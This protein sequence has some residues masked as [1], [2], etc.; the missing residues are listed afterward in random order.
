MKGHD[1]ILNLQKIMDHWRIISIQN[2]GTA[3]WEG[4]DNHLKNK[5][6]NVCVVICVY[7]YVYLFS[8]WGNC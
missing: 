7:V 2:G 8:S 3:S 5:C 6:I 4:F 1:M